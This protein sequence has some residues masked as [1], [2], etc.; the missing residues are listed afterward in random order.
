MAKTRKTVITFLLGIVMCLS[1]CFGVSF[2]AP[3]GVDA[4]TATAETT[5]TTKDVAMMGRVAGWYGNG[6]FEIRLTL[7]DCDWVS[8]SGQ[9]NYN[10]E[11][12]TLLRNF[13][14]FN[15]IKL[16]DKAE[17][18]SPNKFGQAFDVCELYSDKGEAI[19]SAPHPSQIFL[20]RVPFEVCAGDIIRSGEE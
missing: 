18:I 2:A 14:F 17:I 10:G 3:K 9:K 6:N 7:G 15:K 5:Y 1:V 13:D 4:T 19:E 8:E 20:A 16:G 11:L 12:K